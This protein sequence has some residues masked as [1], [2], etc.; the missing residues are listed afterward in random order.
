M[1][2]SVMLV[3]V[4]LFLKTN[5][6]Q[7]R[8]VG[9]GL[10][11]VNTDHDLLLFEHFKDQ[12]PAVQIQCKPLKNGQVSFESDLE[13]EP[14]ALY[15]GDEEG[16]Y[17]KLQFVV[18]QESPLFFR[19]IVNAK[20]GAQY[21]I[22]KNEKAAY[23]L[24]HQALTDSK[25]ERKPFVAQ[26]Y[27]YETWCRYLKRVYVE[28]DP[29]DIYDKPHGESLVTSKAPRLLP[30]TVEKMQGEWIKLKKMPLP[31]ANFL[32]NQNYEGWYQWKKNNRLRIQ[33]IENTLE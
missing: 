4:V 3:A 27:V 19:V 1:K 22:K 8:E 23:Y 7:I 11:E 20:T 24:T 28:L 2:K 31:A 5:A 15:E 26:W 32:H 29:S 21:Y 10:L 6:Q 30:F 13:L 16:G 17:P 33:I 12:D 18:T 9:L 25:S 14:Y